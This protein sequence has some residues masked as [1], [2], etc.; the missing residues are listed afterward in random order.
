MI[1]ILISALLAILIALASY[2]GFKGGEYWTKTQMQ[3]AALAHS[4]GALDK[5]TLEFSWSIPQSVG[6]LMDAIPE[7][8]IT[9]AKKPVKG[10]SK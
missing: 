9:P 3:K 7:N 10:A 5:E 2:A 4:C 8:A 1:R 6:I